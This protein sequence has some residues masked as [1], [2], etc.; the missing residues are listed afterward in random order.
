MVWG[1]A[2]DKT[3][4]FWS[5]FVRRGKFGVCLNSTPVAAGVGLNPDHRNSNVGSGA[6]SASTF[7]ARE[8][9]TSIARQRSSV[10]R[11][12]TKWPIPSCN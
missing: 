5:H 7:Q 8:N 3:S 10:M 2:S 9:S 4:T 1:V 12:G 6:Y 11:M